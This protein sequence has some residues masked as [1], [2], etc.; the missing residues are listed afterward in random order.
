[1]KDWKFLG[2]V[3]RANLSASSVHRKLLAAKRRNSIPF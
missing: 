2:L 3:I 1:M